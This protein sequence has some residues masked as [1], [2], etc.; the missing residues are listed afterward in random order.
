MQIRLVRLTDLATAGPYA[1]VFLNPLARDPGR[2]VDADGAP[3][4][5]DAWTDMFG[6]AEPAPAPDQDGLEALYAS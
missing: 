2:P 3:R 5:V 1:R 6:A 4:F